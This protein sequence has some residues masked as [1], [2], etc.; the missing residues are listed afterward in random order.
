MKHFSFLLF[1]CAFISCAENEI[2]S[3]YEGNLE[4]PRSLRTTLTRS[5][6]F[7]D[8]DSLIIMSKIQSD[9]NNLMMGR[10]VMID[11]IYVL[12]LKREDAEFLGVSDEIY[13][14]YSDYVDRLNG[15]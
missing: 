7:E 8:R 6:S 12:S 2:N 11:S 1:F 13:D 10:V 14:K 4:S 9:V 3:K 5:T 15:M